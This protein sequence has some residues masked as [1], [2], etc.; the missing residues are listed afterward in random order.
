MEK[1]NVSF[2]KDGMKVGVKEMSEE[3]YADRTQRYVHHFP[4]LV[5][6]TAGIT[7]ADFHTACWSTHGTRVPSQHTNPGFGT[8]KSR[9]RIRLLRRE[10]RERDQKERDRQ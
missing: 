7:N 2:T 8:R 9:Q 1:K 4:S 6:P 5:L 3:E 10:G